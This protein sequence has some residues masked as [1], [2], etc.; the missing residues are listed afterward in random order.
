MHVRW[1]RLACLS[2]VALTGALLTAQSSAPPDPMLKDFRWRNI[3]NANLLGRISAIDALEDDWSHVVVGSASGGVWK[4]TNGGTSWTT[5]F[6][7]YASASIGD[8]KINQKDPQIIWVATG[9]A[10]Q[11]NTAVWGDGIYKSTD[12]GATF[13]N[14]G[15]KDSFNIARIRLHPTNPD[16]VYV[17]ALGNIYGPV[18]TRGL[19]KT[20][21]G[22]VTWTKLGGGLPS[23]PMTGAD[24]LVMDPS[25]PET[26][27]ASFWDRIRYPWALISGANLHEEYDPQG[28]DGAVNGGIYK[29]TD[30]GKSWRRLTTGLPLGKVGRIGLAISK[31]NPQTLMAHVEAEFQPN[32]GGGRGG[33][34]GGRGENPAPPGAAAA[35]PGQPGQPPQPQQPPIDPAC[36]D[37]TKLGAG[38]YRSEDGGRT[39]KFLDRYISRPFYY[40]QLQMHPLNDQEVFSYTIQYRRSHD[41]GKT[42]VGAGQGG[43]TTGGGANTGRAGGGGPGMHC[44]HAMWFDPHNKNRYYIGSDGGLALT[45]DDGATGLRFTNINVTQYYDVGLN[46]ADPY[47]VC[48]GLQDAGASCGPTLSRANAIYLSDWVNTSGGDGYHAEMDMEDPRIA[49][50]ESQPDRQGGNI[51]RYNLETRQSVSI[52]PSKTNIV[53]WSTYIT[54]AMEDLAEKQNWGKQPM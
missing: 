50:T 53:N 46:N 2:A 10:H 44:W 32:C 17:A 5:I 20:T 27:Y 43:G 26:L 28:I 24:G 6:D 35:Q 31:K 37:L 3:G 54:Q 14:M 47:W 4:S 49:Y 25:N 9:E 45:H 42:W 23:S 15:L 34:G 8:V 40:M 41:G 11:R 36:S 48:G 19:Y 21:D 1:V 38:M 16:I 22:G 13:K 33:G 39:W 7:T 51:V 52:R 12:G 30:G 18:G 29:T